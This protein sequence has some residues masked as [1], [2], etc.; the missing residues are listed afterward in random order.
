MPPPVSMKQVI[1]AGMPRTG[2]SWTGHVLG[3]APGYTYYREPD[4]FVNVDGAERYFSYL[5]LRRDGNDEQYSRHMDRALRGKVATP[6]TM[7]DNAG[8]LVDRLPKRWQGLGLHVPALYLRKP[9]TLVKLVNSN[10]ALDWLEAQYPAAGVVYLLRHPCGQFASV[11]RLGWQPRPHRFLWSDALMEDHLHP[12]EDVLRSAETFWERAGAQWGAVNYVVHRQ[13]EQ[14]AKRAV[15]PFEWLC[16][17]PA[18][19]F[20]LLFERL[21]LEWTRDIENFVEGHA[22]ERSDQPY[23]LKRKSEEQIDKWKAHVSEE[24]IA[25]C[26]RFAEPFGL[27]FYPDFDP[28][29]FD[30]PW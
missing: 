26:R 8:P 24:D 12:F 6:F 23:S 2:T 27:P 25:T 13:V 16:Q 11:K 14:G 28:W 3:L 18:E 4:N 29:S 10:L 30:A 22:D 7:R 17:E 15:V 5:Y 9:N 20:R 21:G 19:R 1:V